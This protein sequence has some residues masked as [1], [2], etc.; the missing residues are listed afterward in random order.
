MNAPDD[1]RVG[2]HHEHLG[3]EREL[4]DAAVLQKVRVQREEDGPADEVVHGALA[5]G[6]AVFA[7]LVSV[8]L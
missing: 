6:R 5:D 2:Q 3:P 4:E 8:R 7:L 1:D